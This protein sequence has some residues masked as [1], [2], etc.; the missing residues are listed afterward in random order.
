VIYPPSSYGVAVEI[1][2]EVTL[3]FILVTL[4]VVATAGDCEGVG[5]PSQSA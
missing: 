2:E 5:G 1:V 3:T 4:T